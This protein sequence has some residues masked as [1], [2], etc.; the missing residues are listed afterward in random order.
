MPRPRISE[1]PLHPAI[2]AGPYL[3]RYFGKSRMMGLL[4]CPRCEETRERPASE[5]I[6]EAE[7]PNFCGFCR[8]CALV[9]VKDGSHRWVDN[10]QPRRS[11]SSH[12]SGYVLV[13]PKDCPDDL[14]PTYRQMQ[15]SGQPVLEHRLAMAQH[16]GRPL[17]SDELVDHMNGNKTDNRPENLRLYVRGKQQPGS[18]PGHGTFYHEWQLA[19]AEIDRLKVLLTA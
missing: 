3:G 9:S 12:A 8:T 17:R 2:V 11:Y 13:S 5:I 6:K 19:L 7:R 4:K 15:K 10:G 14:L 16:L 1:L 18:A